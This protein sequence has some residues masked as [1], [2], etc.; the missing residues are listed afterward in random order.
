MRRF[1]F[2]GVVVLA[3]V[4]VLAVRVVLSLDDREVV[5]ART[6]EAAYSVQ[7][8]LAQQTTD[9]I[10]V[11]GFVHDDGFAR[12]RLCTGRED[13]D[14]PRCVGPYLLLEGLDPARLAWKTG[15]GKSGSEVRWSDMETTFL[16]TLAGDELR[17]SEI[18]N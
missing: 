12:P 18:L 16:G 3:T 5:R 15:R 6:S 10:A 7:D 4:A 14:P 9:P 8:A 11:I 17:V 1:W 13:S 2:L